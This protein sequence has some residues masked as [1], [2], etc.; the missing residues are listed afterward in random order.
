MLHL[1]AEAIV[2]DERATAI[3][4]L[5]F[6]G[7]FVLPIYLLFLFMGFKKRDKLVLK[8]AFV[9]AYMLGLP[10]IMIALGLTGLLGSASVTNYEADSNRVSTIL[11]F[12]IWVGLL[13]GIIGFSGII[14]Q[15]L[16]GRHKK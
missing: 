3:F 9:Y 14:L 16:L 4:E 10:V 8:K 5:I 2:F 1:F 6:L 13:S 11:G 15:N 12:V 7:I